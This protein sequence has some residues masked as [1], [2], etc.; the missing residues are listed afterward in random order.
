VLDVVEGSNVD[1]VGDAHY[2]SRY[3]EENTFDFLMSVAVFEHLLMPWKVAIE[4]GKVLKPG[5]LAM[6][7]THQTIGLHDFPWDFFRFSKYA[8]PAI[9]NKHTGF[10]II[11]TEMDAP[12]FILPHIF[13]QGKINAE[14]AAGLEASIVVVRKIAEPSIEWNVDVSDLIETSYPTHLEAPELERDVI[15]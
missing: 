5:G 14:G 12:S 7:F 11:E 3:F 13:H 2:L 4:M 6:I 15:I 9:F 8:W 1:V 10:E